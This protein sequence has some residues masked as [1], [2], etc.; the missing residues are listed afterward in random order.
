[1]EQVNE[2]TF[3]P[4]GGVGEIGMNLSIY[5]HGSRQQRSWLAFRSAASSASPAAKP[6]VAAIAGEVSTVSRTLQ[7]RLPRGAI[8]ARCLRPRPAVW[9]EVTNHIGEPSPARARN[10]ASALVEPMLS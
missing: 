7:A 4:L 5:G 6:S 3:A 8:Q 1:M 9:S 2:L 10:K